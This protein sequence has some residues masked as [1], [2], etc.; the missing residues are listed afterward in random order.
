[1]NRPF[2]ASP[3]ATAPSGIVAERDH[4]RFGDYL[5]YLNSAGSGTGRTRTFLSWLTATELHERGSV[6]VFWVSDPESY[7]ERGWWA[8]VFAPGERTPEAHGPF[9]NEYEV[10]E[11]AEFTGLQMRR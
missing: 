4:P 2:P 5:Q 7:L 1:M 10:R 6:R 3:P 9:M 11:F 8:E